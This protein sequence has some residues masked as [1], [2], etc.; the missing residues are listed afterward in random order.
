VQIGLLMLATPGRAREIAQRSEAAGFAHLAFG[1]TQNLGPEAWGQLLLAA[2]ASTR[3]RLGTGVTNPVTR[4]AAVTASAALALQA[5]SGGRAF[6]GI[7]RG[8]SALAKIGQR[9]ASISDFER[10]SIRLRAYLAGE[11]IERG[12]AASRIEWLAPGALPR[13]PLQVAA[14]GP[15]VIEI[16]ARHADE[17]AFCLGADPDTLARAIAAARASAAS[18]G[19]APGS[20]RF[21]AF[22]NCAI[23]DDVGRARELAR[24]G[25]AVFAR[26]EAWSKSPG[27]AHSQA[28]RRAAESLDAH[29]QMQHHAQ[30]QNLGARELDDDFLD[31]FAVLGP[32]EHAVARFRSLAAAGLDFVTI[33]PGSADMD[34]ERG[35]RSIE[36]I[37][38]AVIP[39]LSSGGRG[40]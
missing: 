22:V 23:D 24:G 36:R 3:I 10:Y 32:P 33:A 29:Y 18:A 16:A 21:G 39:A 19:R 12:D 1:D 35:W 17:I 37:G 28:D 5:E 11:S 34:W 26:F 20:L 40:P 4:D 13:V 27:T 9:P 2:A 30:A 15:R 8:D 38:R 14:T 31:R 7:G 25:V 6:C